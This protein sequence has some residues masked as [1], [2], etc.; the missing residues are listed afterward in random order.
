MTQKVLTVSADWS[1]TELKAF[2]LERGI[3]GAPVVDE[4]GKLVGVVS[5]TDLLRS[6]D[7]RESTQ[8]SFFAASLE[9]PLDED[10]LETLFVEGA[11]TQVV[12]D[13][14]TPVV[15]QIAADAEIDEAADTMVRGRIHRIVVTEGESVVGIVTALDLVRALRDI[16]R[17]TK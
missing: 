5:S 11:P 3:S 12:G 16:L 13:V 1:L 14:M 4:K 15:F 6:E 7:G 8:G 17:T 10:E 2:L 9:R